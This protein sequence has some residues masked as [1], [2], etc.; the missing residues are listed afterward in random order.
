[1]ALKHPFDKNIPSQRSSELFALVSE[2]HKNRFFSLQGKRKVD[3]EFWAYDTTSISSY[4]KQLRQVQHGHNKEHDPLEQLNLA[5]VFG[6]E[7]NLPFYYRKLSGNIPDS[8]TIEHLL[9][10]L[11]NLGFSKVKLVM[12]RGFYSQANVNM[13]YKAHLVLFD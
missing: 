2:D 10:D 4:S 12:D 1:M 8:K 3:K 7:S 6:E 5:I 9:A 11:N 13:L